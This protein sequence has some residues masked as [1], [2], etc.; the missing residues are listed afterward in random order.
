MSKIKEIFDEIAA[1]PG[2][3]KK[4]EIL[5]SHKEVKNLERVLKMANSKRIKF[6]IKQIPEYLRLDAP[7]MTLEEGLGE[8]EKLSSREL[9]G[10]NAINHLKKILMNCSGGDSYIIERIIEKDCKIGM[11]TSNINK[12]FPSLIEKTPYQGAKAYDPKLVNKLFEEAAKNEEPVRSDVKMDG[13][14]ANAIIRGNEV[15]VESRQGEPT[16]LTGAK[17]LEELVSF[18]DCVLNG[19]L[20][21]DGVPRYESNGI[22]TSLIDIQSKRKTRTQAETDKKI[23][24]FEKDHMPFDEALANIRF[25]VWDTITVNEYFEKKSSRNLKERFRDLINIVEKHNPT[26][27]SLIEHQFVHTADQ[28]FAHFQSLLTRGL[29]GTI[30]KSLD[31]TWK[32]GKPNWQIKYKLEMDIDLK[33]VGF[34]YGTGKNAE[35][36]SSLN[37]ETSDGLLFTR[38]QGIKEDMMLFITE[39]QENLLG[40]IVEVKCSG[41]SND[42]EGNYSLLHPVFKGFRD[43]KETANTLDEVKTIE[44]AIKGLS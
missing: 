36:I 27:V 30:L 4:M 16:T 23:S 3:N 1:E 9:T 44:A 41:L 15:E 24:N 14:Y 40:K 39:N 17:F 21:M 11:G 18:D 28:A 5:K 38:P 20:T 7:T 26:M 10:H 25:T 8:L 43:D 2:S 19:E 31:G 22:I 42:S 33:V 37:A 6:F 13:R 32:D 34:N 12:I 29:E 35:V